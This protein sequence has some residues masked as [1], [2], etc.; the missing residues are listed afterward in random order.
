APFMAT[1]TAV[2]FIAAAQINPHSLKRIL[3]ATILLAVGL[4]WLQGQ[5]IK[6]RPGKRDRLGAVIAGLAQGMFGVGGP[7]LVLLAQRARLSPGQFRATLTTVWSSINTV[8][9]IIMALSGR[10]SEG[11]WALPL[12]ALPCVWLG[13][14]IGDLLHKRVSADDFR[15]LVMMGLTLSG[16]SLVIR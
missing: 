1:G 2:G 16:L 10:Y 6:A 8:L 15:R 14:R 5:S 11:F 12:I 13:S 7:M 4:N 9:V 3:G